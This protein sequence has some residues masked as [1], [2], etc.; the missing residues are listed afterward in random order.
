MVF[1]GG[2]STFF[3]GDHS[4]FIPAAPQEKLLHSI[5]IRVRGVTRGKT[6]YLNQHHHWKGS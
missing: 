4:R 5:I 1:P 6:T 2:G 3:E